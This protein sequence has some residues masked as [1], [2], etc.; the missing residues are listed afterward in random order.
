MY[1]RKGLNVAG[2]DP[3][4]DEPAY[5]SAYAT[6]DHALRR[7]RY[8]RTIETVE[9][10]FPAEDIHYG[11]YETAFEPGEI[12]RLS[13]FL[14][15]DASPDLALD[16]YNVSPKQEG[17]PAGVRQA[18]ARAYAPTLSFCADRFPLTRA[19]W[20]SYALAET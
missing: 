16:E 5:V 2:L 3:A 4:L 15:V 18:V 7:G 6:S 10:I 12:G 13:T 19:L 14:G 1:R 11:L 20:E 9:C 8:D 17:L